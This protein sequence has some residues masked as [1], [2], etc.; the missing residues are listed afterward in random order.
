MVVKVGIGLSLDDDEDVGTEADMNNLDAFMP[1]SPIP[2]TRIHKD[3]LVEQIIG[4]LN[5]APQTRR[6]T[7]NLK[8][9][10][11]INYDEVFAPVAR[12]ET[13]RLFLAYASFKDF[14]VYQMDVKSAFIYVMIEEEVYV[15][16]PL[17]FE[18]PDFPN[19]VYKVEKAFYGLHQAP[20]AWY[21][22]L[23]TYLLD[24]SSTK[25]SLCTEIEKMMH[26]KFQMSSMGKLTFFLGLQT[27][28][29][30]METKNPLLKDEHG[31]EVDVHLYRSMIGSLMYL[32]S[33]RPD[34]MFAVC[35]CARYQVN[36]KMSHLHA[37]KRIFRYLKGQPKLG[38]Y[39][40]TVNPTIYT[41]CI[42]QFWATA[43]V[44]TVNGEVQLQALVDGKK[45]IITETS[46]RRDLQLEDAEG[47]ECLPNADIFEQLALMGMVKNVDSSVK[48]LMYPRFVQVFLDKQVGDMSTHDEI[49]VTPSHTKKVFGNMKRVGKGFSRAVTPLFP[50]M[51]VQAQ[52]E[53]GE[54]SANPTDPHHTPIITQPSTS[55]PQKKQKPRKPK[56]KDTEIPQ[57]SGPTEPIADEAANEE[58]VPTHSNDPLLSGE[59]SLKLN[60]LMEI[61]TKLQQR[62]LDLENTKTAQ[63][64]E[65]SSLKLRVKRLEKKGGSRTH[66]L[67]RLFKVGRFAQVVSSEYEGLGDQE[68]ASKQGRKIDD[69]DKDSKVTLVNETQGRY[70]DD[71]V[72]DTTI[73]DGEEVFAGHD[74][75]EKEVS[76]ADPVTTAGKVVTTASVEVSSATTTTTTAITEKA[77]KVEK[78]NISWDNVQAMIEA[79]R[80]LVERLQVREQE[81][82]TDEEKARL[83]IELLEKRKKHFA[84]LI[85]Q[86]KRNKPPTI[87]QKK[88]TISK[89]AGEELEQEVAKKQKMEDDKEKEDLKQCFEIV[90][91]DEVAIDA[92]PLATK[93]API[94]NFQIHRKGR[95]GYYEIMRAD[96]SAKTYLLFSQLLK[97]FDRE[98]LENLW[99]LVKAKHGNTR[100][101]E[102]YERVLWGD[103]KTMFE[104]HV[105][106]L[107]WRNL[108]GKKVLLW[109]LY[110]SCGIHF[111][112]FEDMHVYMLVEKRYP[113]TP[114]T[115]TDMLNKKLQADYW[116]EMCY[117]LLK[118][119]TK[120]LK[121]Q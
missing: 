75:V 97:E 81:E 95:N 113:L 26:K 44:K 63:A 28:S 101:E 57:S 74:V 59:D 4:D 27:A 46:V 48:F 14:V 2:T 29:T 68:D 32:T 90:Q 34:I 37:V 8:E 85:A 120:Q 112:R 83:F 79:D 78:A 87:A 105:E 24:N 52:E 51:M 58:N 36:L 84:A 71:L 15:Y 42:H 109:R 86:E 50:T 10:E 73:L 5:S 30:P 21:E 19:R 6:M 92:I 65:I 99:K 98:D 56:R 94:V 88:S 96:G 106:D 82:L 80:L 100:P 121:K 104:H 40:L 64:Q 118:L 11:G 7:K 12:I 103:L 17:G 61:C 41:S 47:I 38:L 119:M 108:Q 9:D 60:D 77:E 102:G 115:I 49:F 69:I 13:I 76:T 3:H 93:P 16:Q 1:V 43:K 107:I 31:E 72:F 110:D 33:S 117:Q 67:K 22:T 70:G 116:N 25:K 18:D 111:V 35:A 55:K 39:A 114:A 53:M 91:D 54:G 23:S 89:R 45:V 62:V 20:R 66:K